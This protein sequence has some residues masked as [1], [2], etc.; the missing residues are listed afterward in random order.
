MVALTIIRVDGAQ[1]AELGVSLTEVGADFL[2]MQDPSL[3]RMV[4][5][6]GECGPAVEELLG[7]WRR[8]RIALGRALGSVSYTHL[9]VYK[10]QR[11]LDDTTGIWSS[12]CCAACRL[13]LPI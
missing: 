2:L 5:G 1:V 6:P 13:C 10:R 11:R 9:D 3:E 4:L 8:Q 7:G 12:P